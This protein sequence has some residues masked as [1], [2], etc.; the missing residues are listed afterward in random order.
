[1]AQH[2]TLG[3]MCVLFA[4]FVHA[5]RADDVLRD[6]TMPPAGLNAPTDKS[7]NTTTPIQLITI[8]NQGRSAVVR[9]TTVRVGDTITEGRITGITGTGIWV[10]SGEG[11][12]E[13]KLFPDVNR[14]TPNRQPPIHRTQR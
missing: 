10:K 9:G 3:V 13:L 6:P 14:Q 5:A 11:L 12:S 7:T 8:N 1:M 2:L 4:G